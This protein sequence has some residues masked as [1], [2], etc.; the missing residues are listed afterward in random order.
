MTAV[1]TVTPAGAVDRTYRVSEPS[2]GTVNR[3]AQSLVELSGKGVNIAHALDQVG[4]TVRAL[5]ILGRD[6]APLVASAGHYLR[7]IY[8]DGATR[9]NTS[10]VD[11]VGQT[12][13]F[14][15]S[16]RPVA[17]SVWHELERE[18]LREAV[19]IEAS[20]LVIAGSLPAEDD[21][22]AVVGIAELCA[23]ARAGGL[24]V[25]LD[26]SGEGLRRALADGAA[27]D[28]IKPNTHELAELLGRDLNTVGE[29]IDA[30]TEVRAGGIDL[31]YVS[32]GADGAL[33][34]TESG[35]F[36]GYAPASQ[37]RNATGA[38]DASLAGF[39][40]VIA[41]PGGTSP[42]AHAEAIGRAA[43]WGARAVEQV[44]TRVEGVADFESGPG[45]DTPD[46]DTV[47]TDPGFARL[48]RTP[49]R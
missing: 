40:S 5:V 31:V 14:N 23:A 45:S 32:M 17:A 21:S 6:D 11:G 20:W 22:G 3:A 30:A 10:V 8:T 36:W 9:V 15:E 27:L 7:P 13:K 38:G 26:S 4:V 29:V 48:E 1:V 24:R 46:R 35:V 33:L 49:H 19:E 28:L 37:L 47:L 2:W 25:A 16:P 42:E 41:G 44:S 43:I 34:V 39:L 18:A 12:T